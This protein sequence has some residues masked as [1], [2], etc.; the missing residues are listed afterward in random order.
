[1]RT[2]SL[3]QLEAGVVAELRYIVGRGFQQDIDATGEHL[4]H[5]RVGVDNGAEDHRLERRW[6]VPVVLVAGDDHARVGLPLLE[7]ERSSADGITAVVCP[8]LF[9]RRGR[10]DQAGR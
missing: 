7:L 8:M 3:L 1:M 2:D 6:P 5:A 10:D 4:R 9:H